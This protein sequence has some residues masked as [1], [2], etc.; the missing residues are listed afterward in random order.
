MT[1]VECSELFKVVIFVEYPAKETLFNHHT[2][3][4]TSVP[5][6][7][8]IGYEYFK[9]VVHCA[10]THVASGQRLKLPRSNFH[11]GSGPP[12]PKSWSAQVS[13]QRCWFSERRAGACAL[14]QCIGKKPETEVRKWIVRHHGTPPGMEIIIS[15][16][17][18]RFCF[19]AEGRL[20]SRVMQQSKAIWLW[21]RVQ[22]GLSI[23]VFCALAFV[24][25]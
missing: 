3:T 15:A 19:F 6:E 9:K 25:D 13:Y 1:W 23:A 2:C 10:R 16:Q 5:F 24:K 14:P 22:T 18:M 8:P 11:S 12:P 20:F 4:P 7:E 17:W 21:F